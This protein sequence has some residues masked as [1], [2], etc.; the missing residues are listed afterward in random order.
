MSEETKNRIIKGA[1]ELFMRYGF[2][3]ITM[4]EIASKLSISKK[5]IYQ[6]VKDKEQLILLSA[7]FHLAQDEKDYE[8]IE[9]DSGDAIEHMHR[10][11]DHTRSL[12]LRMNPSAV[13]DMKKYYPDVWRKIEVFHETSIKDRITQNI[14]RGIKDGLYRE[15]VSPIVFSKL[16]YYQF[17]FIFDP[18]YFNPQEFDHLDV[19]NQLFKHFLLGIVTAK[20][21][22]VYDSYEPIT[23]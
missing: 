16:L 20:G 1:D 13:F 4:D 18:V 9:E 6:F 5:T 22:E 21:R 14:E 3:S 15:D 10:L 17:E 12:I 2:K 7:Q 23:D 19:Y 8:K 11:A